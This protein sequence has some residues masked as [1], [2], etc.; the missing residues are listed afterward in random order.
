MKK[1]YLLLM[2]LLI[3]GV[4][5]ACRPTEQTKSSELIFGIENDLTN[6]D[7]IKS[8]E[9]YSLQVIGQIF[10]GLVTLNNKNELEPLLA[11]RW[12][13][14][15]D[16]K[17]WRFE[18]RKGVFFHEDDA[19]GAQRTREV[20]AEDA[21]YSF[22]R[23]VSKDSYPSFVLAD[24]IVGVK[25]F[26]EGTASDVAGL[27]AIAP[28]T[29]EIQLQ[30][31]E[32]SFLHRLT[33]PWFSVFPK[34]V[35]ALGPDVFGR[36]KA[37]GTGPFRLVQITRE[38]KHELMN[39][40]KGNDDP[41]M[42]LEQAMAECARLREENAQLK[43]LLG[44]SS[45]QINTVV[46]EPLP[47]TQ[48]TPIQ[49][50]SKPDTNHL[51][52]EAKITLFR[53][54]FRGR[55]DVYALRWEGK[56]GRAGY[57]PA[58]VYQWNQSPYDK[59]TFKKNQNRELLP[60]TD[61]IIRNHLMGKQTVGV[62]PLLCDET[63]WF[64]AVDF[65]KKTWM[66]DAAAFL[67]TCNEMGVPAVLERSRSGNGAHIWIF[68]D[69]P[70]QASVAR[71][72]GCA[73]LTRT[74]EQRHQ[75][76]LDSY[77]RF[78]PNQDTMPKGGFGNLIA[79]PLQKRPRDSGNSVFLDLDFQPY[80][81]QW[82]ILSMVERISTATV[83]TLVQQA[84]LKGDLV[85][86]RRIITDEDMEEAPWT[87]P[88]SGSR[89]D[90]PITDPLPERVRIV[91][92][93]LLYIEKKDLP[94]IFIDRL[95][96]LAAFQNPEFYKAQGMRLSTFGKPRVIACS[97][98]FPQYIGLPR[99]CLDDLLSLLQIHGIR[100][101]ITD[102][103][104]LGIPIQVSFRGSLRPMQQMAAAAML[105]Y[106]DGIF[107][108]PTA[109]GKTTIAAWLIAERKVNTLVLVHRRHLLD[110]WL[111]R[112]KSFLEISP[113]CIGQAGGGKNKLT[114]YIDVGIIQSLN[115]KGTIEDSVAEYGQVIID[116]CHH[117]SAFTFEQVLRQV[118][119]KYVVGLTATPIRKDGHH[120]IIMMQCGPIRFHVNPKKSAST[121][122]HNVVPRYTN[123]CMPVMNVDI[124][125]QDVYAALLHD[126]QRN[127]LIL[128]D[129]VQAVQEGRS[130]LLI[131]ERTEHLQY[132]A[133]KLNGVIKNVFE[134]KGGM[135]KKQRNA[136]TDRLK[137]VP[138]QEQRVL[139]ATGR[140]IGEGFDDSRLD[141]LFLA[142]PISW[143]GTLQQYVGRLH[144]LHDN[145]L[146]VQVYDYADIQVPMLAR[147]FEKRLKGY[148][149]IG[150]VV[151]K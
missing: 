57:S 116:E 133:E 130:P 120:P 39:S 141:T 61:E 148:K 136:L 76:G 115:R 125:I 143:R 89:I 34:E 60:L 8:Q 75:V 43:K 113:K 77:D 72:L 151:Q 132:F 119:A 82:L 62:Y 87:L 83:E 104:I 11:E 51:S 19:F 131:T 16:F 37:I 24:A 97:E 59:A 98:E 36:T 101:D 92:G 96:R 41:A 137:A 118:K 18:I 5:N 17:T 54:L 10:E 81:D 46:R 71:K 128:K 99:G 47:Q 35:V 95:I 30:Q 140:Y 31:S 139:I 1:L 90:K 129:L 48:A 126:Q 112:L 23:I 6:L 88:P 68:F 84:S 135:G 79:L 42:L 55:E 123:F 73:I 145:K 14:S 121:F 3:I 70:I 67:K 94:S 29:L 44:D 144:R 108:A 64:L 147:M 127:E 110:Q 142:M 80:P 13:H 28:S 111:E 40:P 105:P 122:E 124:S 32:P 25:E 93:N 45:N 78:F 86:V 69:R 56:N 150:Y 12:T 22:Q 149:A 100:P 114:G 15:D 38:C 20:T 102:E 138:D 146:V 4:L 103:R 21:R 49:T 134:F 26:Q 74:M 7:P 52:P 27:R 117:I 50:F 91:R 109:F 2:A 106:D 63:C 65:D 9:P 66:D 85:G 53:S 107:C 58:C 33:S